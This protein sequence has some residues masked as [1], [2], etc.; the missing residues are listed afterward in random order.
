M[1]LLL[2][3]RIPV[4]AQESGILQLLLQRSSSWCPATGCLDFKVPQELHNAAPLIILPSEPVLEEVMDLYTAMVRTVPVPMSSMAPEP[5]LDENPV[6]TALE[7]LTPVPTAAPPAALRVEAVTFSS[8]V[9]TSAGS[10]N[11]KGS[12]AAAHG[13]SNNRSVTV[14]R[15]AAPNAAC[16]TAPNAA[17][18][19]A[20]VG[21]D[22]SARRSSSSSSRI[23][24]SSAVNLQSWR[25]SR[26]VVAWREHF[27]LFCE[28][29]QHVLEYQ[30]PAFPSASAAPG[31]AAVSAAE[32]QAAWE[33][34]SSAL[35][36]MLGFLS[37]NFM[38]CFA[39]FLMSHSVI[40]GLF[41][42]QYITRAAVSLKMYIPECDSSAAAM[43]H[44]EKHG[45]PAM[46]AAAAGMADHSSSSAAAAFFPGG[47]PIVHPS[48]LAARSASS[49]SPSS[50]PQALPL[51]LRANRKVQWYNDN[52]A[53]V[54]SAGAADVMP[55][56]KG[57]L[58]AGG[59]GMEACSSKLPAPSASR[60]GAT[61]NLGKIAT[62][63][64]AVLFAG[65]M[66]LVLL[67]VATSHSMGRLVL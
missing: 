42:K 13:T 59:D 35:S 21:L 41:T 20:G 49:P 5:V 4:A 45:D 17:V 25:S 51:L 31:T 30:R 44:T 60:S 10:P 52:Q 14:D 67:L 37:Q 24:A 55:D 54:V 2:L 38:W 15:A 7:W 66:L 1:L 12:S 47:S 16:S 64:R 9:A 48:I 53:A 22:S 28:D 23:C 43:P 61:G 27:K 40:S 32:A 62:P 46:S 57:L 11:D 3:Y 50:S 8:S 33:L 36:L 39:S 18:N 65:L 56:Q 19:V 34:H 29:A 26:Q 6:V 58:V 63:L